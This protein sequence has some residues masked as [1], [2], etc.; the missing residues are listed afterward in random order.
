VIKSALHKEETTRFIASAPGV[1]ADDDAVL[2]DGAADGGAGLGRLGRRD[3][4][5]A[6]QECVPRKNGKKGDQMRLLKNRPKCIPT[7]SLVQTPNI[8]IAFTVEKDQIQK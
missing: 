7:H 6:H 1:S 8:L 4:A 5:G 3:G 2:E